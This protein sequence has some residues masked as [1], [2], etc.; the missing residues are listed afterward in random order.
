[1]IR[2]C[3][4]FVVFF[5]ISLQPAF[6]ASLDHALLSVYAVRSDTGEVLLSENCDL[7][8]M[9]ASCMKI[10]TT[11]AALHIL[12]PNRR[13][14]TYLEYD[15]VIDEEKVLQGNIYIRGGGDPCLGSD[16][17][18]GTAS[19][20]QQIEIWADAIEKLGIR[21]IKGK[22]V[23]DATEW[24]KARAVPSWAWEDL[25]NYYGAG[26]S[27]L[28]FHE[29]QYSI[30]FR[31]AGQIGERVS[32]LRTDPPALSLDLQN[33]VTTGPEGSGDCACIYGSEF[34]SIQF[35]RGT[36]PCGVDEFPIKG[37]I[38]NP[39]TF[40]ADLLDQELQKRGLKNENLDRGANCKTPRQQ[41]IDDFGSPCQN[42][43]SGFG[44]RRRRHT[45]ESRG[46][47]AE[48]RG[49]KRAILC[50]EEFCNWLQG[51][52]GRRTRFHT[53]YSPTVGE[54]AYWTNQK[55]VN[56]YAEHLLKKMG[57][58]MHGDGST[59]AGI[60]AVTDFWKAQNVDLSGFQ[61]ADGSGL[62]RKNLVTTRQLVT[63]LLKMKKSNLF[64]LYF[65]SFPQKEESIRAK[66]GSMS[67]VRG[68]AGYTDKTAFAILIN[69]CPDTKL[70]QDKINELLTKI[71]QMNGKS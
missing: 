42:P 32:V 5:L 26:A 71:N 3:F 39:G 1:M 33:E 53:T 4:K 27:A 70:M 61:M 60:K 11:A 6:G 8:M 36:I 38:P 18:A 9:P 23:A 40:C 55:S 17:I 20:K 45:W 63:V 43:H 29:N 47:A 22:V 28:S 67:L 51:S 31:P 14:E 30:F 54:I 48:A 15:G 37:M 50:G 25:G 57:E 69:Q 46:A 24:E 16:R 34:S 65:E 41:K 49:D 7:S 52:T 64:P 2:A 44:R 13:L 19:W 58:V 56:L 21:S 68:F 62:S 12:G 66:S 10:V 35:I 59:T